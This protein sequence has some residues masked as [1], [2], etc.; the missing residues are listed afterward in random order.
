MKTGL[1]IALIIVLVVGLGIVAVNFSQTTG[2]ATLTSGANYGPIDT[3]FN[4]FS[5]CTYLSLND[6]WDITYK[7][8]VRAFDKKTGIMVEREDSCDTDTKVYEYH[9]EDGYMKERVAI[10]PSKMIC[11]D[12]IC[13]RN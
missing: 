8:R 2:K 4:T 10:C 6:G 5:E 9:C 1:I 7:S 12:G 11:K 3:G 13:V